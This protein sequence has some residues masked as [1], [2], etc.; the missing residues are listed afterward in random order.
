MNK[1]ISFLAFFVIAVSC[2]GPKL[3]PGVPTLKNPKDLAAEVAKNSNKA[4]FVRINAT[5]QYEMDGD[6]QRFKADIRIIRDSVIWIE[7]ADPLLGIKAGRAI[8]MRDS[9]AFVNKIEGTY[10]AG[11]VNYFSEI[12]RTYSK[13]TAWRTYARDFNQR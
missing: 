8:M 6:K 9:I 12:L 13:H 10:M 7:L 2:K 1:I 4:E 11:S 3:V 5:G